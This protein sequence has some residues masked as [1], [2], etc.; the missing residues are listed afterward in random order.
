MSHEMDSREDL[1]MNGYTELQFANSMKVQ[2]RVDIILQLEKG[3]RD[4]RFHHTREL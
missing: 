1:I 3:N 2:Y 4:C